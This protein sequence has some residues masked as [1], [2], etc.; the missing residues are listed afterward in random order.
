MLL[1]FCTSSEA[2]SPVR[3]S[4]A[5]NL[6]GAQPLPGIAGLWPALDRCGP[7]NERLQELGQN[8]TGVVRG[9]DKVCDPP[10]TTAGYPFSESLSTRGGWVSAGTLRLMGRH[11][12]KGRR[13]RGRGERDSPDWVLR[14]FPRVW[15]NLGLSACP[16]FFTGLISRNR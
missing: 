16:T 3:C 12:G 7:K 4:G 11:W 13:G 8:W 6:G 5:E 14:T 10:Q 9:C 2:R 15:E 1:L